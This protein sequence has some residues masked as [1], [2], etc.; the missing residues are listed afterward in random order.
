MYFVSVHVKRS[1]QIALDTSRDH[2]DAPNTTRGR[3]RIDR[4]ERGDEETW[5]RCGN[6]K[7]FHHR[8]CD[9]I[10]HRTLQRSASQ[11]NT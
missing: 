4:S 9:V 6:S 2:Y 8:T 3:S 7:T 1:A 10:H 5:Q 11:N